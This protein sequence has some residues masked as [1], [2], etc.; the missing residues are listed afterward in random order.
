MKSLPSVTLIALAE[1]DWCCGS[2]G[3]YSITQPE[4]SSL[5][6]ERKIS[7]ILATEATVVATANPGC[8]LQIANGL[9]QLDAPVQVRHP[10]S[11]LAQAY[12]REEIISQSSEGSLK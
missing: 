6:L 5:L 8:H 10:V 2:A 7:R 11:L 12:R 3:I 9:A 1:A 4:Q